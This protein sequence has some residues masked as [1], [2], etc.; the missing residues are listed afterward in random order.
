MASFLEEAAVCGNIGVIGLMELMG[1][2]PKGAKGAT[3]AGES[4]GSKK[5]WLRNVRLITL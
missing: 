3:G 1:L 5:Y 4:C 2:C